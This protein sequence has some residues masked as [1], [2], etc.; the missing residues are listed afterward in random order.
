MHTTA[1]NG[2]NESITWATL[3]PDE[4]AEKITA[5]AES[6]GPALTVQDMDAVERV[7]AIQMPMRRHALVMMTKPFAWLR[8]QVETDRGGALGVAEV[9]RALS[10]GVGFYQEA[11]NLMAKAQA[12]TMLALCVREDMDALE[13]AAGVRHSRVGSGQ[14]AAQ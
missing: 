9:H 5:L 14:L 3:D 6:K 4:F 7:W 11:A 10:E 1:Q 8:E 13:A 12:L 2:D